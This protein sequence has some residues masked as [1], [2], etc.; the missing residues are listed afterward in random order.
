[1]KCVLYFVHGLGEHINRYESLFR[2]FNAH[3]IRVHG[4]DNRGHGQTYLINQSTMV[5]GHMGDI[6]IAARDIDVLLRVDRTCCVPRFLVCIS[7]FILHGYLDGPQFG[8]FD[9][10]RVCTGGS[11]SGRI[12][13]SYCQRYVSPSAI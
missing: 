7:F 9:C 3:G 4:M 6:G 2:R 1:M 11:A 13:R 10:A 5:R 12:S 8:W